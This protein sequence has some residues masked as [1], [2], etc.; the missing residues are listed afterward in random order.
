[1]SAF[2]HLVLEARVVLLPNG[3]LWRM[4]QK[5]KRNTSSL[6][7]PSHRVMRQI[8]VAEVAEVARL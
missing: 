6:R 4:F 3:R 5:P 2:P 1:M 8:S 7:S